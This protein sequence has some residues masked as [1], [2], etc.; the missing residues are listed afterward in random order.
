MAESIAV[1]LAAYLLIF[2]RLK[3]YITRLSARFMVHPLDSETVWTEEGWRKNG[4][5]KKNLLLTHYIIHKIVLCHF[6]VLCLASGLGNPLI[7][8]RNKHPAKYCIKK[9]GGVPL[10]IFFYFQYIGRFLLLLNT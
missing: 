9:K 5:Y 2:M 8:K 4:I 6:F 10:F 1:A 3:S 7:L